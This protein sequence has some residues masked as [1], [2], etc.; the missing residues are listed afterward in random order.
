MTL[1]GGHALENRATELLPDYP[2]SELTGGPIKAPDIEVA[3]L[4]NDP[5]ALKVVNEAAEHLGTALAGL[6]NLMNPA[7]VVLGG[8]FAR[9]GQL[10]LAPL[11]QRVLNRTLVSSVA[12]VEILASEL[13]PEIRVNGVAPG[14][15]LWPDKE[16]A[17]NEKQS[18]LERTS[19]GRLGDPSGIA[20]ADM[21][22][23]AAVAEHPIQGLAG[24]VHLVVVGG[25]RVAK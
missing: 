20:G 9:L 21:L 25:Q 12:A 6:L 15:I 14:A 23:I 3:A 13:G 7:M 17:E 8:D 5:L 19:L 1:V 10:F 16:P 2:N 24:A 4:N 22:V 11:R 18:I